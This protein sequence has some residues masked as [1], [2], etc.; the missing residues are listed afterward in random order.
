M[1]ELREKIEEKLTKYNISIYELAKDLNMSRSTIYKFMDGSNNLRPSTVR[2][3]KKWCDDGQI[4]Y[5]KTIDSR[6]ITSTR[7][8]IEVYNYLKTTAEELNVSIPDIVR[9]I[10]QKETNTEYA[11]KGVLENLY[12][13]EKSLNSIIDNKVIT[14]MKQQDKMLLNLYAEIAWL[15][16]RL[17]LATTDEANEETYSKYLDDKQL[18]VENLKEKICKHNKD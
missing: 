7:V 17:Y 5:I 11:N 12:I 15:N 8:P 18:F 10:L 6:V 3:L 4:K 1:D 13:V 9:S 16:E 14:F 2:M